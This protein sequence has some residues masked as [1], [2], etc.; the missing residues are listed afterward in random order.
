VSRLKEKALITLA[1]EGE[2]SQPP[3]LGEG[4]YT[5]FVKFVTCGIPEKLFLRKNGRPI[6]ERAQTL[7]AAE[8]VGST[9]S[10][11]TSPSISGPS[12]TKMTASVA[13]KMLCRRN[14]VLSFVSKIRVLDFLCDLQQARGDWMPVVNQE[15]RN[16]G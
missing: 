5:K 3:R 10:S 6:E 16:A 2:E 1:H 14:V 9:T 11:R 7:N 15:V 13:R 8:R 12:K 4:V